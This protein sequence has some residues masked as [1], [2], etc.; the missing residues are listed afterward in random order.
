MAQ[1]AS[2]QRTRRNACGI[3]R[4]V[5][6][7]LHRSFVPQNRQM[8]G[9]NR[10]SI[11]NE[12]VTEISTAQMAVLRSN[13]KDRGSLSASHRSGLNLRPERTLRS[14]QQLARRPAK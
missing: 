2:A 5:N 6:E 8:F 4:P 14:V 9:R 1:S 7:L 11:L 12:S 3:S 13:P 10:G